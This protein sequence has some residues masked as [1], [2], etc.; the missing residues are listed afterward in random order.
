MKTMKTMIIAQQRF[1]AAATRKPLN[2]LA[3]LP[4]RHSQL[5]HRVAKAKASSI[6]SPTPTT[7]PTAVDDDD[8]T[9]TTLSTVSQQQ[10]QQHEQL[11]LHIDR[12][13][14]LHPYTSMTSP[15]PTHL[16][17]SARGIHLQ[18]HNGKQVIDG[19]SSWWAAMHGYRHPYLDNA[20]QTQAIEYM[21]HVMFGGLSHRPAVGLA[22]RLLKLVNGD[23]YYSSQQ[24]YG[25]IDN[26]SDYENNNS[27]YYANAD[28]EFL[29]SSSLDLD[30]MQHHYQLTKVFLSDSG[31]ISIEVAMKMAMQY[32][33]SQLGHSHKN[34]FLALRG[35]YHGDTLGAMSVCDP[36][37]GMRDTYFG[38]GA[39]RHQYFVPNPI[40]PRE[41][42]AVTTLNGLEEVVLK[43]KDS[44][45]A[46]IVEP[47]VQGAGGMK[48][49]HPIVL[50]RMRELCDDHGILLIFDE[51]A[52]G[53]GRTGTLFAGWHNCGKNGGSYRPWSSLYGY[54]GGEDVDHEKHMNHPTDAQNCT[55]GGSMRIYPDILCI[56]K[57]LTGGYMT[58]GATLTT[59]KVARGISERGGVFMHGP[60]FMANPLACAVSSAS[61][62]LL[63]QSPWEE[64]V[65]NVERKLIDSLSPLAELESVVKEVRVLGAI[66]VCE[67]RQ[68]LDREKMVQVQNQLIDMGVWLRPFGKLLYTMPPFN[69]E[70]LRDEYVEKIGAAMLTV[71]SSLK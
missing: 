70:D 7:S 51:I 6:P 58:M 11:L 32:W 65:R 54:V 56:G 44:I 62:N 24:Q 19:M 14:V 45:A 57:A 63:M 60:T 23:E 34:K 33:S 55:T 39:V 68:P 37:N 61:M 28:D 5:G 26:I 21:S 15:I 36:D 2:S 59:N 40:G 71:A 69:C 27:D 25:R 31:S 30:K 20:L 47:I 1:V 43:H 3:A 53:F 18:L 29:N 50:K 38:E 42:D 16:I 12:H 4:H 48:F 49:Y 52:T 41:E 17:Q 67:L 8:A 10:R 22:A 66:G 64:R 9:A 35:G 13:H 46:M